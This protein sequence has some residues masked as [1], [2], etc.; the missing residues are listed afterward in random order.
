MSPKFV[1]KFKEVD[2]IIEI[3]KEEHMSAVRALL[4]HILRVS[5]SDK[6]YDGHLLSSE[7]M[8]LATEIIKTKDDEHA[9]HC[10]NMILATYYFYIS[11]PMNE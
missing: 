11:G 3:P 1:L 8:R 5:R 2:S 10:L 4:H 7:L 9:P 6:E